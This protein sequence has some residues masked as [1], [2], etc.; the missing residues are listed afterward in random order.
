[1]S[2]ERDAS[3]H[4]VARQAVRG[5]L[6]SLGASAVTVTLGFVRAVLLA[7][8]L[9]P[10]QYGVVALATFFVMGIARL[11]S[12][13]FDRALVHKQ[14]TEGPVFETYLAFKGTV[15]L[16]FTLLSLAAAPLIAH[17]YPRRE[18]L[19]PVM[20]ALTLII[21]LAAFNQIQETALQIRLQFR[22][23]ALVNVVAAITMTVVAPTL[24]WAGWG[25]WSLVAEQGSGIVARG[26]LLWGPLRAVPFRPRW[27][28][29]VARWF[30]AYGRANWVN[31]NVGYLLDRFD[32]FWV[33]TDLGEV[34]LGFYNRAYEFARYPRRLLANSLLTVMT[35]VFARLQE[36]RRA[37][38]QAYFRLTSLLVRVGVLVG[39]LMVVLAPEF[40]LWGLGPQW[41]P[42]ERTF[43]LFVLYV[44][45]DPLLL[46]VGHLLLAVGDPHSLARARLVQMGFFLPA[47]IV[48]ARVAGIEGVALAA[49]LMLLLGWLVL[50]RRVRRFVDYS[51]WRLWGIPLLALALGLAGVFTFV[52]MYPTL[53]WA[54][55][56]IKG[57]IFLLLTGG[58][59]GIWEGRTVWTMARE[60]R[61]TL[62]RH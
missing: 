47:V 52:R 56:L 57:G 19:L 8:Y 36:N 4:D 44:M 50:E 31:A 29:Q 37:L 11:R 60:L 10:A 51:L 46:V 61:G 6:Y 5:S 48:A 34:A 25:V 1:M 9:L 21:A 2:V 42:M 45:L 26:I 24:A 18:G 53:T 62:V 23:I 59:M 3:A 30:W 13:G 7:H 15:V 27:H 20:V 14:A 54:H 22:E 58:I 49:D 17:F 28:G 41:R 38:S 43:Q 55:A 40:I 35:P 12:L 16:L 33:G 39:G 32:D